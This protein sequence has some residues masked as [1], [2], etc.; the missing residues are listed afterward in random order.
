MR[1]L[2]APASLKGSLPAAD[3]AEALVQGLRRAG[4][5]ADTCPVADGGDGTLDVL[6][7]ALRGERRFARVSAPLGGELDVPYVVLSRN[8]PL[9][10]TAE[11]LGFAT[12]PR[13]DAM[14][15]SSRG[16]GELIVAVATG[17][18]ELLVALGGTVTVDAGAGMLEVL[19]S[20]PCPTRVLCDVRARPLDAAYVF[21]PQKGAAPEELDELAERMRG[22]P[23]IDGAGAAGGLGGAFAALGADLVPGARYVLD[24]VGFDPHGYDLVITGEGAVDQTTFTGKAAGEVKD[25]CDDARVPCHLFSARDDLSG[26]PARAREDLFALGERLARSL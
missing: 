16:L 7:R 1:V 13:L 23:D 26:D 15:A 10:G 22:L 14:R 17:A 25:R 11:V 4:A 8:S 3:A 20:L 12:V 24:A 5:S 19:D 21:A 9:I 6:E 18:D 2:A